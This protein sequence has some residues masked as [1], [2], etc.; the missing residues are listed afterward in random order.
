MAWLVDGIEIFAQLLVTGIP[1]F[2]NGVAV[3]LDVVQFSSD[4]ELNAIPKANMIL[5]IGRNMSNPTK[6][7]AI[8]S[9]I[10]FL[11]VRMPIVVYAR[12]KM[13]S[14]DGGVADVW[15]LDAAGN[16][17]LFR[18]WEG[19]TSGCGYRR[20][21]DGAEF[22]LFSTHWLEDLNLSSA[23]SRYFQPMNP[24][25]Y[26]FLP[27]FKGFSSGEAVSIVGSTACHDRF[28]GNVVINDFWGFNSV[29]INPALPPPSGGIK[30][31]FIELANTDLIDAKEIRDITNLP[32]LG[33]NTEAL[34]ALAK[35]EPI[36]NINP[37]G[38]YGNH[39]LDAVP[40]ALDLNPDPPAA[41]LDAVMI[42]R[43]ADQ[44]AEVIADETFSTILG[45]TMWDKLVGK[46]GSQFFFA[47]SPLVSKAL[48][49]PF[50]PGL[51][52]PYKTITAEEYDHVEINKDMP[53]MLR[54]VAFV[55]PFNTGGDMS[56]NPAPQVASIGG[57]FQ[58]NTADGQLLL[59]SPPT[60][61]ANVAMPY[62]D[63][64]ATING[65]RS[66]AITPE[67][68]PTNGTDLGNVFTKSKHIW[69]RF[70]HSLYIN[71]VLRGRHGQLS[72]KLRFDIAP[73]STVEIE[74]AEEKFIAGGFSQSIFATVLRVSTYINSEARKAG[75]AYH[76]AYV[77]DSVENISDATSTPKHPLWKNQW[78][79]AP[80][81]RY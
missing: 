35:I 38:P 59:K 24:E 72:G 51:Q 11:R 48:V 43:I 36:A 30:Q 45:Q 77:R 34:K 17:V 33:K 78:L 1:G 42:N 80:M 41:A 63:A 60:W 75:T 19:Y 2:N 79:G 15:P 58:N 76:L 66:T 5:A 56:N 47:V 6:P 28:N 81:V 10:N 16:P 64:A 44:I 32:A 7:A 18:I 52:S 4:F 23:G 46:F 73:G 8:H 74:G 12:I 37:G 27:A 55:V 14:S 65:V 9:L 21:F 20:T 61:L 57:L 3:N 53:R 26:A 62:L 67:D 54:G 40:L 29:G 68:G 49:V 31:W 22:A 70:A 69:D 25:Q 50:C 39:Y 13:Q 71:E